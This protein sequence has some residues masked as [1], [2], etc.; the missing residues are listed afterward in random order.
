MCEN[1]MFSL[2]K[3]E[4]YLRVASVFRKLEHME[5]FE[6]TRKDVDYKHDFFIPFP[7]LSSKG[8]ESVVQVR[9]RQR[10]RK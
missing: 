10:E 2:G 4:L 5:L 8:G 9:G 6:T 1:L 3:A 7:D